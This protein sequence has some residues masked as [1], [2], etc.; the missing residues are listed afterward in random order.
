MMRV[1][2][3][4]LNL[5]VMHFLISCSLLTHCIWFFTENSSPIFSRR[6]KW[7]MDGTIRD[8]LSC[9]LFN[10]SILYFFVIVLKYIYYLKNNLFYS[11][12]FLVFSI[13]K[14]L[15]LLRLFSMTV[16]SRS[17]F[18]TLFTVVLSQ[19]PSCLFSFI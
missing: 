14:C 18:S 15:I 2:T 5:L 12:H 16:A 11:I 7:L 3:F 9:L 10:Q 1:Q 6:K 19:L 17:V 8:K 4:V 13:P